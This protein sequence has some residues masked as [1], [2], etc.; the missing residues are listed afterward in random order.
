MTSQI[1][2]ETRSAVYTRNFFANR[3]SRTRR[4]AE[5][6]VATVLEYIQPERV[7]DVGCGTGEFLAVFREQGVQETQGI[8]GAYVDRALLVIPQEDFLALDL[9]Q[10]FSLEQSYDLAV[11]LEVA[12]HLA[13][14]SAASFI[15]SLTQLTNL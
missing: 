6:I 5:P 1:A 9:N 12:E 2:T 8:D 4:A 3:Q 14:S 15:G 7:V 11:C 10:P 13:P